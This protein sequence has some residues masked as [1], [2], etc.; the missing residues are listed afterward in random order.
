MSKS[1]EL[2]GTVACPRQTDGLAGAL[3][4]KSAL[5]RL[6]FYIVCLYVK[7]AKEGYKL[8]IKSFKYTLLK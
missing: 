4:W 8:K 1:P 3:R 7:E 6:K 2:S 5:F